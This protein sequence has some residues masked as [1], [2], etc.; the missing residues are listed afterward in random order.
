[1]AESF[2]WG[3]MIGYFSLL[4]IAAAVTVAGITVANT[5]VAYSESTNYRCKLYWAT[6]LRF[7][8]AVLFSMAFFVG[9]NL[10][11]MVLMS[12][13][14]DP[15]QPGTVTPAGFTSD[16]WLALN[17]WIIGSL[18]VSGLAMYAHILFGS[19]RKLAKKLPATPTLELRTFTS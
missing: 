10:A 9:A 19:Y 8:M 18:A 5:Y 15:L 14:P 4:L 16:Q 2:Q 13:I 7:R 1:M 12:L 3:M 17:Q 11:G 6:R